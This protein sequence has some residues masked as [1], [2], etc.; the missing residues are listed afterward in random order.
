MFEPMYG[1]VYTVFDY[2]NMVFGSF[3]ALLQNLLGG[4]GSLLGGLLP[5]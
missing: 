4:L 2:I 3:G 1:N 5:F